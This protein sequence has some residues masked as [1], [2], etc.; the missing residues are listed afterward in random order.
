MDMKSLFFIIAAVTGSIFFLLGLYAV[1]YEGL[2][3]ASM[4][5]AMDFIFA[6]V[7]IIMGVIQ[8]KVI[9]TTEKS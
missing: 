6:V 8:Y 2:T 4:R 5:P 7:I 1:A 3:M 9:E